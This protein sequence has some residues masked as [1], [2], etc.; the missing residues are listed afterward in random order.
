M[1]VQCFKIPL[2]L[3]FLIRN[4][5]YDQFYLYLFII[6]CHISEKISGSLDKF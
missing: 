3:F 4:F 1:K 5:E 2:I 6:L